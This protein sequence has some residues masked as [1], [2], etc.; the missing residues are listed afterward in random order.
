MFKYGVLLKDYV[1]NIVLKYQKTITI[2]LQGGSL[3]INYFVMF[4]LSFQQRKKNL[5]CCV[6]VRHTH[7]YAY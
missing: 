4:L 6:R 5:T 7:N 1:E 3:H 2:L